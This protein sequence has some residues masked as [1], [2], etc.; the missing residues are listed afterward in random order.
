MPP[1]TMGWPIFGETAG[2]LKQ[3][4]DFMKGKRAR[5]LFLGAFFIIPIFCYFPLTTLL[6]LE[7]KY[8]FKYYCSSTNNQPL[9]SS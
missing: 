1:G 2:F 8:F 9:L 7:M 3:G 5:Y 6:V 4:P